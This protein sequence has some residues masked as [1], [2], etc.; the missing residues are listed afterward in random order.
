MC[1]IRYVCAVF[2]AIKLAKKSE[3]KK[4]R[5]RVEKRKDHLRGKK[6]KKRKK[7]ERTGKSWYVKK[8]KIKKNFYLSGFGNWK[9]FN[10]NSISQKWWTNI[11][12]W[13]N[14]H[15]SSSSPHR[16]KIKERKWIVI[17]FVC[18]RLER[19]CEQH[20]NNIGNRRQK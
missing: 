8:N 18:N 2:W 12:I 13:N 3:N 17:V 11:K 6:G 10:E 19:L 1:I 16:T 14:K 20:A 7:N 9:E 5:H 4:N 15:V